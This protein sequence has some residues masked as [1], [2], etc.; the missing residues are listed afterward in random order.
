MSQES[1]LC[2]YLLSSPGQ[3]ITRL[4]SFTKLGIVEL[5]ARIKKLEEGGWVVNREWVK[6]KNRWGEKIRVKSYWLD[7]K[8]FQRAA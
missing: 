2:E 1:R 5:S 8:H 4:E 3:R 6:V 7:E